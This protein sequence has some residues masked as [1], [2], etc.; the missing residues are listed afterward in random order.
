MTESR[1]VWVVFEGDYD[2]RAALAAFT[3]EALAREYAGKDPDIED[4]VLWD[5]SPNR[6]VH[7]TREAI[8]G[9]PIGTQWETGYGYRRRSD[10][11]LVRSERWSSDEAHCPDAVQTQTGLWG[12]PAYPE[13]RYARATGNDLALVNGA[14]ASALAAAMGGPHKAPACK[15]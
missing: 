2:Q 14:F 3:T 7:Y 12:D 10:G 9:L 4:L 15:T 13:A 1:R 6:V 5:R 8:V 11:I